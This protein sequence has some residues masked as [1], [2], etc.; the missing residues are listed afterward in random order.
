MAIQSCMTTHLFEL[1][2][3]KV[4]DVLVW[5][6]VSEEVGPPGKLEKCV[7]ACH[8]ADRADEA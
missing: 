5:T 3:D 4:F 7:S 2:Q 1:R 8:L 6:K